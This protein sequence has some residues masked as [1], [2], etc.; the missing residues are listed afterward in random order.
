MLIPEVRFDLARDN[1]FA[2]EFSQSARYLAFISSRDTGLDPSQPIVPVTPLAMEAQAVEMA[3]R[4]ANSFVA[5]DAV[6]QF[7]RPSYC[8]QAFIFTCAM[9][10][11]DQMM[12]P[13]TT[14][15]NTIPKRT[16]LLTYAPLPMLS[17]KKLPI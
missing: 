2:G 15:P 5:P 10:K 7:V 13:S 6:A 14:T 9:L 1:P 3:A 8:M 12:T 16:G 11:E 4:V 17:V